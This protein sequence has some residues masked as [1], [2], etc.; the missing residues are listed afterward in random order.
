MLSLLVSQRYCCWRRVCGYGV[1]AVVA[2]KSS[3][4]FVGACGVRMLLLYVRLFFMMLV[5]L[6]PSR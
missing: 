6:S 4:C 2:V 5:L 3:C 1:V